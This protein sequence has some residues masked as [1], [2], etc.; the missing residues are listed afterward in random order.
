[1]STA[2]ETSNHTSRIN[3]AS[4]DP[5]HG[6]TASSHLVGFLP[7]ALPPHITRATADCTYSVLQIGDLLS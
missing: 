2:E 5:V 7:C 4:V 3:T 1:M 6:R